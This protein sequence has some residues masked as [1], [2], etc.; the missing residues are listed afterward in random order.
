MDDLLPVFAHLMRRKSARRKRYF[1]APGGLMDVMRLWPATLQISVLCACL[2]AACVV[3]QTSAQVRHVGATAQAPAPVNTDL[4]LVPLEWVPPAL[5]DLQS[6]AAVKSSFTFDRAMLGVAADI[7][8][9]R[10]VDLR[11]SVNKLDGVS[12]HL[13][14]FGANSFADPAEVDAVRDAYH[15]RG[16]KHVVTTSDRG[17]PVHDRSTDVWVVMD[18]MNVRGAVVL[19]ETPQSLT[20]ITLAGDL[21][22]IDLLHLRGHFGIPRFD[23]DQ[24]REHRDRDQDRGQNRDRR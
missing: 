1:L 17:S 8:D 7:I 4:S 15:L 2:S 22:P 9:S 11:R 19:A 24:L 5:L 18:G 23:G 21:S 16:W 14:K 6:Q 10:D 3:A 13:L 20:L 12:F